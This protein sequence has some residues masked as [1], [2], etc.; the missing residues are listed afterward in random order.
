MSIALATDLAVTAVAVTQ[1][2][3][4]VALAGAS[5]AAALAIKLP[6]SRTAE[7]E[8]DVIGIELAARAGYDPNAAVSLWKKMAKNSGSEGE[9]DFFSTHPA[10]RKRI[11]NLRK[12]APK[13]MRYYQPNAA[14]PVYP[15]KTGLD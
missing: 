13:M 8:S 11:D 7:T 4:G 14:H 6:N 15:L 10:P 2:E 3:P 1:D 5:L 9:F 12:L